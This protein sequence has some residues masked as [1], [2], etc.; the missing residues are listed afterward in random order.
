MNARKRIAIQSRKGDV[1]DKPTKNIRQKKEAAKCMLQSDFATKYKVSK[2]SV[3]NRVANNTIDTK[4]INGKPQID[5]TGEKT[6]AVIADYQLVNKGLKIGG[7]KRPVTRGIVNE[8]LSNEAKE[9]VDLKLKK[10]Q[11]EVEKLQIAVDT[12]KGKLI[13]RDYVRAHVFSY[14]QALMVNILEIPAS[15]ELEYRTALKAKSTTGELKEI[16]TTP[17]EEA[18]KDAEK[19]ILEKLK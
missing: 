6:K 9:I 3:S 17:I 1:S 4:V 19:H 10:E 14:L 18:I 11:L 8:E 15:V 13:E 2:A 16:L 12:S 7:N 5:L